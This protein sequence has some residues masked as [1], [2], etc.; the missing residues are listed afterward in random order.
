VLVPW[1]GAVQTWIPKNK[2]E[3]A[4][5][6]FESLLKFAPEVVIFGSGRSFWML[7]PSL[8]R[9]LV[10]RQTG[11]ESMDTAAACRTFNVLAQ[12]GRKVVAA[13]LLSD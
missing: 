7:S 13:L 2:G 9:S 10:A 12:E 1:R 5:E 6:H 8:Y 3:L 4:P 11:V